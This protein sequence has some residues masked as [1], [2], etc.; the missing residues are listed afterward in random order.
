MTKTGTKQTGTPSTVR[1]V[2]VLAL[3]IGVL[4]MGNVNAQ[5]TATS[6][7]YDRADLP[8]TR[9]VLFTSGVGYFEYAG[10]VNG[11][12]ELVLTV[13]LAEMDDL[14]QSLVLQDL[15]GGT[16]KPVTYSSHEPLDRVLEDS[17]LAAGDFVRVCKQT[18]DL[19]D[20]VSMVADPP[21][22]GTAR[23]ALDAIRRGIV[24]Y[25]SVA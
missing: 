10:E 5:A 12:A 4:L 24:A 11:N 7:A 18:I 15:G 25:S 17:E 13:P 9:L 2:S 6:A 20:Q 16:I 23:R 19:L 3:M 14:L 1:R 8:V 21:I 22:A